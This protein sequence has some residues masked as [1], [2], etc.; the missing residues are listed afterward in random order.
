MKTEGELRDRVLAKAT[1]D[2]AFRAALVA[3]PKGTVEQECGLQF[4]DG[5]N[6]EVHEETATTTHMILP[7]SS[8][9]E[10][11]DLLAVAGGMSTRWGNDW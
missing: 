8:K 5:Y 11:A 1:E 3:D 9:L 4:P 10:R 2:E 6:L 7:P